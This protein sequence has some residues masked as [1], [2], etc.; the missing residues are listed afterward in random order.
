[1][2]RYRLDLRGQL[3]PALTPGSFDF[4]YSIGVFIGRHSFGP[5]TCDQLFELLKPEGKIFTTVA[6]L[7]SGASEG[8]YTRL[9]EVMARSRFA[10][11]EISA[12]A[13]SPRRDLSTSIH[14]LL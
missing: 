14:V 13:E 9:C 6:D 11:H 2:P 12:S 4:I 8:V 5:S 7:S 3:A 10:S 1:V